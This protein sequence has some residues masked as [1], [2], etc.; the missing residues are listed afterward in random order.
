MCFQKFCEATNIITYAE[1]KFL[2]DTF[3]GKM[4]HFLSTISL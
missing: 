4:K 2:L 1:R 3:V